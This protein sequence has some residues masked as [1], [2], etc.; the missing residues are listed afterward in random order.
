MIDA[1]PYRVPLRTLTRVAAGEADEADMAL[2]ESAQR[3]RLLLALT[4]VLELSGQSDPSGH[5]TPSGHSGHVSHPGHAAYPRHSGHPA[6]AGPSAHSS[7]PGHP[8]GH[9][10]GHPGPADDGSWHHGAPPTRP[11]VAWALLASVQR[12]DPA[13]VEAVL[14]DPAVGAWA[15]QQVRQLARMAATAPSDPPPWAAATLMGSL[16]AAAAIRAGVRCSLRVPA[17]GGR[18][19]LPSLGLTGTVGRGEWAVVGVE[20]GQGGTVVFGD[21]GSVRMPEDLSSPAEGWS[22]LP[23]VGPAGSGAVLDHL[24]PYR[25]FRSLRDPE[26]L[27]GG[28][29][30]R[31]GALLTE[32]G[33]LLRRWD[34]L[35]HRTVAGTV[36]A[37]VPVEGTGGPRVI[38]ASVP[39]AY[40]SI[41]LSLPPDAPALA[42]TLIHEAYHQLLTAVGDLTPLFVSPRNGP[43]PTYFAPWRDDPRPVRGLLF[44]AHAF[45]GVAA[46]WHRRRAV[47]GERADFEFALLRWQLRTA[48][49]A[50]RA[51][52]GLTAAGGHVV[53]TLTRSVRQW[54]AEPV[55]GPPGEL[56]ALCSRDVR[57]TWRA[58]HL[59]VDEHGADT[60]AQRLLS[61][62]PPP[63]LLPPV[64]VA[65]PRPTPRGGARTWL[66]RLWFS[67]REAF[68]RV[69]AE[70]DSGAVSPRGI[71]GATV[72]D[73]ALIA[74]DTKEALHRYRAAARE[75]P[76][77]A[78]W[79]GVGLA[80]EPRG[81]VLLERPELVLALHRA[82]SR[83]GSE[84]PGPQELADWLGSGTTPHRTP[85][86]DGGRTPDT[87]GVRGPGTVPE[88][89]TAADITG[90]R[91][92][93]GTP[94]TDRR[95]DGARTP[96]TG[97]P[98]DPD[99]A[100]GAD[101]SDGGS[102]A[103]DRARPPGAGPAP[104]AR[105]GP[106]ARGIS[107]A[108][109]VDV[110]VGPLEVLRVQGG[111]VL[112]PVDPAE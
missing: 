88:T 47:D 4:A 39:D 44:G 13:A 17:R 2:L 33:A 70:L 30:A 90:T 36:R 38:S 18:L 78:A 69:R 80:G 16:A 77:P 73:A 32:A 109:Q 68:D 92:G 61:G 71:A 55:H 19:W 3:S 12:D 83:L 11:A 41:T 81:G 14:R 58:A 59:V 101:R 111:L 105:P 82:L 106:D 74:G 63:P 72:A 93:P 49:A 53:E 110:A 45:A 98:P 85:G 56:A 20:C 87:G 99:P 67:D 102:R 108:Q 57:A 52:T 94:A 107:D 23:V 86:G 66:A 50:L 34:P 21:G 26:E 64:R 8:G 95:P 79:I 54:W 7:P 24:S 9:A 75:E 62:L 51:A 65:A 28:E 40:G 84:P 1:E 10:I 15:F 104:D 103:A 35:A 112:G 5:T 76:L 97:P 89:G 46:F 43:E 37:L 48:L 25:D 91:D 6:H 96:D 100:S 22:P 42:A 27:P 60:L 29:A 31:W